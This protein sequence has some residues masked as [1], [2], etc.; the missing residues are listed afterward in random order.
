M[1]PPD[2]YRAR[3]SLADAPVLSTAEMGHLACELAAIR[4]HFQVVLDPDHLNRWFAMEVEFKFVDA[5]RT[6][7]IKQARPYS[8]GSTEIPADCRE[9]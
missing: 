9:Y 2:E 3:S 1:T 5:A 7:V 4:D 6:L 8:F